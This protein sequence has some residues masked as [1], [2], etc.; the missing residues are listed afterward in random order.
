MFNHETKVTSKPCHAAFRFGRKGK[1]VGVAVVGAG[2]L[3]VA[4]FL[5]AVAGEHQITAEADDIVFA[6]LVCE[7]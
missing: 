3:A 1:V 2:P 4:F 7:F 5:H 6:G